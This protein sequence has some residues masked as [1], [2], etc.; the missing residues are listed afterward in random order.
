MTDWHLDHIIFSIFKNIIC[1]FYFFQRK[2]MCD[3]GVV[4]IHPCSI[5]FNISSQSHPSTPP[6]LKN[7][8]FPVHLRKRKRLVFFIERHDCDNRIRGARPSMQVQMYPSFPPLPNS[9]RPVMPAVF[10]HES[11]CIRLF[12]IHDKYVRIMFLYKCDP[13]RIYF[14]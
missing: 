7:K 4:S 9:I 12:R 14:T 6:V 3:K 11:F 5:S 1:L 8:I 2:C 10:F 13:L